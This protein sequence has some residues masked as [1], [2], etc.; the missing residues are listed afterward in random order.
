[1]SEDAAGEREAAALYPLPQTPLQ[2]HSVKNQMEKKNRDQ[3]RI[4]IQ[5]SFS[6]NACCCI[7]D[8]HQLVC[9]HL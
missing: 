1:M 4:S 2:C 5:R 7:H 9:L 3:F 8:G 6:I